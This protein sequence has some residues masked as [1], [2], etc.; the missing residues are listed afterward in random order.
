[1]AVR[2]FNTDRW[3]VCQPGQGIEF[4]GDHDRWIEIEVNCPAHARFDAVENG[5]VTFLWAGTG[6]E[7]IQFRASANVALAVTSED[8]IWFYTSDGDQY[9]AERPHAKSFT[10]IEAVLGREQRNPQYDLMIY[11]MRKNAEAREAALLAE[12]EALQAE[13]DAAE[14]AP[15]QQEPEPEGGTGEDGSANP[16]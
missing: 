3:T 16:A 4:N 15:Q 1:M 14:A 2:I 12:L 13:K 5:K 7:K 6:Y 11:T 8:E 10:D 9:A